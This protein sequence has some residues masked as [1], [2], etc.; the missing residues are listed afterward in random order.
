MTNLRN[1]FC[2]SLLLLATAPLALAQG[3][4]TQIDEPNAVYGTQVYAIDAAGDMVG[5]FQD[6]NTDWHGFLFSGGVYTTIDYPGS[7]STVLTGL[8]NAGQIVGNVEVP[9]VGFLYDVATQTF[10]TIAYPGATV[11]FPSSINDAGAIVGWYSPHERKINAF[12]LV[13]SAYM[14][15]SPSPRPRAQSLA[16]GI[17]QAGTVAGYIET[18]ANTGEFLFRNGTYQVFSIPGAL[19]SLVEGVNPQGTAL[20]GYYEGPNGYTYGFVYQDRSLETLQFPSAFYTY[21]T[22]VNSEGE[23]VGYF[24]GQNGDH[25]FTW[26]PPAA[27]SE[28]K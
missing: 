17:T 10:T 6:A 26:T 14:T 1:A 25:G 16:T 24:E 9:Q 12:E 8:N 27:A 18:S 22:G 20:V 7:T 2:F 21:A 28:K 4:Y 23:V 19:G 11:T 13:G 3:T 15:I 5:A